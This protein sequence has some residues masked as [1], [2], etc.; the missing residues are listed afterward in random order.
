M[1]GRLSPMV[2]GKVQSF[3]AATWRDELPRAQACGFALLEWVFDLPDWTVNPIVSEAGRR[4]IRELA[5]RHALDVPVICAD[6]FM[7]RPLTTGDRALRSEARGVLF[8][9]I[10]TAPS[11]GVHQIELPCIGAASLRAAA[12]AAD[13]A[14]LFRDLTPV[15][16]AHQVDLLLELDLHPAAIAEF[17]R[18]IDSPRV[19]VNYDTGNSAYWGFDPVEEFAAY[20]ARIR[21]VHIKDVT[22]KDYTVP[23]GEGEVNFDQAFSLLRQADYA[24]D[25]V[26]QTARDADDAG[27]ARRFGAF[28]Q[29]Y[30]DRY[31]V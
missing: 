3:P 19:G 26:L 24:G 22:K 5:A 15:L 12:A 28:T 20:G 13:A 27:A 25:F 4:E 29:Q 21:N 30:I 31:L 23:L 11:V 10:C 17:F 1:Q 9:L 16:D 18:R 14:A 7:H 2:D 6:Y 8:D